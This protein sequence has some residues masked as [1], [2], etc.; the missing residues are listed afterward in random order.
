VFQFSSLSANEA[1]SRGDVKQSGGWI[2]VYSERGLGTTF[3]I[4]LP[5][6]NATT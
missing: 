3:K 5:E 2:S 1:A 6:T 4:F